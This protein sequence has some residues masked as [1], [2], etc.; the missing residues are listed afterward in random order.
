MKLDL[1]EIARTLG[2][3]YHYEIKEPPIVDDTV[4]CTQPIGGK[5]DFT[6]T[7]SLIIA[8]GDFATAVQLQCSRCLADF[9][10][11]VSSPLDEQ[12]EIA[13]E[14]APV[15]EEDS[16]EFESDNDLQS[17]FTNYMLDITELIRQALILAL[18][19]RPLCR[20]ECSGLCLTCG[21]NLNEARCDCDKKAD[22]SPLS[23]LAEMWKRSQEDEEK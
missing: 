9:S 16:P 3:R 7:G 19:L 4:V 1:S 8:K 14:E 13:D 12:F 18:P 17:L 11:P 10:I 23:N 2:D 15:D 22:A 5:I 20:E 6:N 21:Q